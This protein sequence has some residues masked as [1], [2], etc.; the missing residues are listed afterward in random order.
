MHKR[1]ARRR[2]IGRRRWLHAFAQ[3]SGVVRSAQKRKRGQTHIRARQV[4]R[5]HTPEMLAAPQ[6]RSVVTDHWFPSAADRRCRLTPIPVTPACWP[7]RTRSD[8]LVLA[9][10]VAPP[11]SMEQSCEQRMEALATRC[12]SAILTGGRHVQ[13]GPRGRD[14]LWLAPRAD[15]RRG[16]AQAVVGVVAELW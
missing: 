13:R 16:Y 15:P 5:R 10:I 12:Y 7:L 14:L 6:S 2:Q 8:R 11:Q 3:A 1:R 4:G 9:P